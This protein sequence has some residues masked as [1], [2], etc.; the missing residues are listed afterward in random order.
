[1]VLTIKSAN[2]PMYKIKITAAAVLIAAFSLSC[3]SGK[4]DRK[5]PRELTAEEL[6]IDKIISQASFQDL[7]GNDIAIADLKG[8]VV[9]IDFWETW[10]GPCLQVFPVMDS[11]QNEY[12]D[13]FVVVA[14]NL[15]DSDTPEDVRAFKAKNDYGFQYA[16]DNN[17]VGDEVITLGIPFKIFMDPEGYLIKAELGITGSDYEDTKE[18]IEQYKTS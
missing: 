15:N 4:E 11:L 12:P 17:N 13:D 2:T 8:K 1:M 16:I 6:K 9:V 7:E 14:V 10:C 5:P 18:I 3:S